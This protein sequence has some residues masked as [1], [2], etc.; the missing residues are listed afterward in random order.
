M[1]VKPN[2]QTRKK[3]TIKP[4]KQSNKIKKKSIKRRSRSKSK[5][6]GK[7]KAKKQQIP[8][9]YTKIGKLENGMKYYI[10][11]DKSYNNVSLMFKVKCGGITE[12]KYEGLSHLLEHVLFN[13]TKKYSN[14]ELLS[15]ELNKHGTD[16][17]GSTSYEDTSYYMT[18]PSSKV[19]KIIPIL[20]ELI[21]FSN[22]DSYLIEKEKNV[23]DNEYNY[24]K[25]MNS[26]LERLNKLNLYKNSIYK[27][28]YSGNKISLKDIEKHHLHAYLN[29]F[30]QPNNCMIGI[31]GDFNI[32]Q[33]ELLNMIKE[34]FGNSNFLDYYKF[35]NT[36]KKYKDYLK[37]ELYFKKILKTIDMKRKEPIKYNWGF[38]THKMNHLNQA[39]V[40]ITFKC[41]A[42]LV[43][44]RLIQNQHK[45]DNLINNY[46]SYPRS[47]KLHN[48]LRNQ[49]KLIY[50]L[51]VKNKRNL[52]HNG[53]FVIKYNITPEPHLINKSINLILEILNKLKTDL[54]TE[55]E[56]KE[57][58][59]YKKMYSKTFKDDTIDELDM[60]I[61]ELIFANINSPYYKDRVK[62]FEELDKAKD[63]KKKKQN[64]KELYTPKNIKKRS[65]ELFDKNKISINCYTPQTVKLLIDNFKNIL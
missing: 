18:F 55:K 2:K 28:Q 58:Q 3:K 20:S 22:I 23:L 64:V 1:K 32:S 60:M 38:H 62:D 41:D 21:R 34:N 33:K 56:I 45:L 9:N 6:K 12:G 50:N 19:H 27:N 40:F 39:Y 52:S 61:S 7:S 11:R 37:E 14:R 59:N 42:S 10:D 44:S 16:F 29:T 49:E 47:G 46:L 4:K 35:E 31:L 17:N 57:L 54:L 25:D 65:I 5:S 48:I 53:I 63:I 51:S 8:Q 15:K 43:K 24:R 26:Y 30:Y 13:G 36:N